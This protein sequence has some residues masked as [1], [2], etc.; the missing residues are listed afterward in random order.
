MLI[1]VDTVPFKNNEPA[2]Y[3]IQTDNYATV[4]LSFVSSGCSLDFNHKVLSSLFKS[5]HHSF[6]ID[7]IVP[8]K[9]LTYRTYSKQNK[10]TA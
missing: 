9:F 3:Y 4:A 6:L 1:G 2:Y 10:I 7:K 5:G 8:Q